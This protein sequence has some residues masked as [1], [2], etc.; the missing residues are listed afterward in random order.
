MKRPSV[1]ILVLFILFLHCTGSPAEGLAKAEDM[2]AACEITVSGAT[3]KK[4]FLTDANYATYWRSALRGWIRVQT[5][6]DSPSFGIYV[7][8]AEVIVDWS[9]QVPDENGGWKELFSNTQDRFFNQF[10]PLP[11]LTDFRLVC[12][13]PR[14][15]KKTMCVS[16][17]R[18]LDQGEL[19][20]WVQ[21]WEHMRGDADLM[22]LAAHPDDELLWF[23]GTLPVYA[24]EQG[25]KVIVVYMANTAAERKNE[26]LDGLWLCGVRYYPE[27][28]TLRN[29]F[30]LTRSGMYR[31]WNEDA[32]LRRLV[33]LIRVYRPRVLLTHDQKGEY[34]HGAHRVCADAA[35]KAF[36]LAAD[37]SFRPKT[38]EPW[39]VYKL[40][41]HL[42]SDRPLQMDWHQPLSS[43]NGETG[44]SVAVRAF[45]R[46]VSQRRTEYVVDDSGPYDCS[47]FGLHSSTVG[48]DSA[49]NDFFENLH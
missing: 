45:E 41:L 40:Y 21:V 31:I 46:H 23:G 26:A 22:L 33:D 29:S 1:F 38:G 14:N 37:P 28:G 27:M 11:G 18:V 16:E 13:A 30:S 48:P 17:I 25:K 43:F 47:L 7:S 8:W 35:I 3:K 6:E 5:P 42:F 19:P 20:D 39:Q 44:F 2:T 10:I 36:Q 34:G 15:Q 4:A 49:G 32:V 24:G 9:I 12:N